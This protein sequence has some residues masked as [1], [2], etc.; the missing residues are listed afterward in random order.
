[1]IKNYRIIELQLKRH[2]YKTTEKEAKEFFEWFVKIIPERIAILK[3]AL[4]DTGY[5]PKKLDFREES[6]TYLDKWF[7]KQ[8]SWRILTKEEID[9][10][11]AKHHVVIKKSGVEINLTDIVKIPKRAV[12]FETDSLC[13]DIGI[14][15][16]ETLRKNV[17]GL[18]WDFV[19]KPKNDVNYHFPVLKGFRSHIELM[20]KSVIHT[21]ALK[22]LQKKGSLSLLKEIYYVWKSYATGHKGQ[23]WKEFLE[24]YNKSLKKK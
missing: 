21:V 10:L 11:K 23:E 7:A 2:I 12:S 5:N 1:M 9:A 16:A 14:Y 8:I 4:K 6:L 3:K 18:R 15:F 17:K 22:T 19:R 20:P 24:E 13:W